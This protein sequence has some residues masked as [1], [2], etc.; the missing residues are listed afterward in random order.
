MLFFATDQYSRNLSFPQDINS[1]FNG[2]FLYE[3]T[4][5]IFSNDMVE[6]FFIFA[7]VS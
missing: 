1:A 3:G 2:E 6:D 5:F 7:F 4:T